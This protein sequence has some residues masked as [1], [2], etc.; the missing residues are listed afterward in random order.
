MKS[1]LD[2]AHMK[3]SQTENTHQAMTIKGIFGK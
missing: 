1:Q 2:I 3:V